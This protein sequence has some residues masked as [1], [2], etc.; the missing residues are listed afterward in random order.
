MVSRSGAGIRSIFLSTWME[1]LEKAAK[2]E[3]QF[4]SDRRL[5]VRKR[6]VGDHLERRVK[7]MAGVVRQRIWAVG[8]E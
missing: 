2:D 6:S 5:V 3:S 7:G 1:W 8:S 4:R